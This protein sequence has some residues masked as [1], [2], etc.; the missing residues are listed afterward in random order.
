MLQCR[1]QRPLRQH[2][3]L[4][5]SLGLVGGTARGGDNCCFNDVRTPRQSHAGLERLLARMHEINGAAVDVGT[6]VAAARPA[7]FAQPGLEVQ[8]A[9]ARGWPVSR[10]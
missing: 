7:A 9:T 8:P 10:M 2:L 1:H 5:V 4:G 6:P 3:L